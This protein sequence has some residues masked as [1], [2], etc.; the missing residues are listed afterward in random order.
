MTK[1]A[2]KIWKKLSPEQKSM[3]QIF[4]DAFIQSHNF[5]AEWEGNGNKEQREVTAHNLALRAIWE[6][7]D[8]PDCNP[9]GE[10][11]NEMPDHF[12]R[13]GKKTEY[14]LMI[15]KNKKGHWQICYTN[16]PKTIECF[17]D[18]KNYISL[19]NA[20]KNCKKYLTTWKK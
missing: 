13:K 5:H 10:L 15:V 17:S 4:Y 20:V 8:S 1:C 3:W 7:Q 14:A 19:T 16:F 12:C 9:L 6:M 11:L 2:P 18:D